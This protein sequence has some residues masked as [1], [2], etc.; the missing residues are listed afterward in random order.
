MKRKD[1]DERIY[2]SV[3]DYDQFRGFSVPNSMEKVIDF[4]K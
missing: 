3:V 4:I 2:C 1:R